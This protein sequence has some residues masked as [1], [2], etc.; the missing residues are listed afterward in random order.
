M[1]SGVVLMTA[2]SNSS[3]DGGGEGARVSCNKPVAERVASFTVRLVHHVDINRDVN[4]LRA[5]YTPTLLIH[6]AT[7]PCRYPPP[8]PHAILPRTITLG[9]T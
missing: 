4:L 5:G 2:S 6:T 8:P 9:L 3:S 1:R 7:L